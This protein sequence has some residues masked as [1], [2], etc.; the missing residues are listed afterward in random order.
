MQRRFIPA[1]LLFVTLLLILAGLGARMNAVPVI[2]FAAEKEIY[3]TFDDGPSTSVTEKVLDILKEENIKATFF[4]VSD[5]VQGRE[6]TL[7]R[8]AAE[9]HTLGV[10]SKTH[11]YSEIYSSAGALLKDAE[12]CAE[13]IR[14]V[15]GINPRVYR[16]PGGGEHP[17]S[18]KL[19]RQH[20]YRI[21]GWN[22]VCGDEEIRGADAETLYSSA[23]ETAKGKRPV[24]LLMHDSATHRATAEALPLIIEHFRAEGY[25]FSAF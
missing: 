5:R 20:G 3:L 1:V 12:A 8:I 24:V 14:R 6:K 18:A 15:T 13:T 19:L 17:A 4:I 7:R 2:S 25:T 22:A 21:V 11:V 10:H 16:F 23:V 9:G